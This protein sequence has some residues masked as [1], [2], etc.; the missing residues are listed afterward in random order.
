LHRG[1]LRAAE[2]QTGQNDETTA[3]WIKR[4]G[5][6]AAALTDLLV[7]E[8]HLSEVGLDKLWSFVGRK[9]GAGHRGSRMNRADLT[10]PAS[11][12]DA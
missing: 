5:D 4:L 11:A 1:S 9:G 2:E 3:A 8:L 6:H 7:R 10:N 12:G